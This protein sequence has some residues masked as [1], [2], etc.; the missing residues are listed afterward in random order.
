MIWNVA[1]TS[2]LGSA[3][4]VK[5]SAKV[6]AGKRSETFCQNSVVSPGAGWS[7]TTV[8]SPASA[9]VVLPAT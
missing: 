1:P 9:G 3:C 7:A 6:L 8:G 4:T 2:R 5:P